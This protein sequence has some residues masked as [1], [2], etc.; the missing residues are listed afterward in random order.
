[1]WVDVFVLLPF[2]LGPYYLF[3]NYR[4]F[5]ILWQIPLAFLL[6]AYTIYFHGRCGQTIGKMVSKVKVVNLKGE[7]I[8]WKQAFLRSSVE[9]GFA[10]PISIIMTMILIRLP[11]NE[12][13]SLT[14]TEYAQNIKEL[15]SA[16][17]HRLENLN[18]SW[19]CSEFIV[20]LFNKKKRAI[21]DFIAGTVVVHKDSIP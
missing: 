3:Y 12:F 15:K 21:H 18:E 8:S 4:L 9:V 2:G 5:G 14:F 7:N 16:Y 13:T 6:S 19:I 11:D 1:M 20:L 17:T 10:I